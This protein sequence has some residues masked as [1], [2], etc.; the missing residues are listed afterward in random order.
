MKWNKAIKWKIL[1]QKKKAD[2]L[3][4]SFNPTFSSPCPF[5]D[6]SILLFTCLFFSFPFLFVRK[7]QYSRFSCQEKFYFSQFYPGLLRSPF[8][9][10]LLGSRNLIDF[11][12]L[13]SRKMYHLVLIECLQI[14]LVENFGKGFRNLI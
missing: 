7:R 13:S 10:I 3:K 2:D 8:T 11:Q 6:H 5:W 14:I 9:I 12:Y 4:I 1:M